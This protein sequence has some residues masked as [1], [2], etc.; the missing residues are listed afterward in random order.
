MASDEDV[1]PELGI[2]DAAPPLLVAAAVAFEAAW[3]AWIAA[4]DDVAV[5]DVTG[6]CGGSS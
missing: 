5:A 4:A 1:R 3:T 2:G 6:C